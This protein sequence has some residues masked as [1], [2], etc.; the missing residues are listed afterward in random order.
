MKPIIKKKKTTSQCI[1]NFLEKEKRKYDEIRENDLKDRMENIIN[2]KKKKKERRRR[3][4]KSRN[5]NENEGKK[6]ERQEKEKK[7]KNNFKIFD[8]D[9]DEKNKEAKRSRPTSEDIRRFFRTED[10]H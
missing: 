8:E 9:E 4:H 6:N 5:K 3:I 10:M 2:I 1:T 7:R